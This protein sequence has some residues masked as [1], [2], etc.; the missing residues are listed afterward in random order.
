[1][2]S[3]LP[4][5]FSTWWANLDN[6]HRLADQNFA[7][8]IEPENLYLPDN[9]LLLRKNSPLGLYLRPWADLYKESGFST[10]SADKDNYKV[11]LDVQQFKPEEISVKVVNK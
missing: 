11:M 5:L 8:G 4:L 10:V 3:L 7:V 9:Y 2:N 6:P 1:M